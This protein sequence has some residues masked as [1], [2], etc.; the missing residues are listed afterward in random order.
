MKILSIFSHPD[1]ETMLAGGTLALLASAGV[2]M[3]YLCATRGEGGELGDPPIC[4][5]DEIGQF[6]EQELACAVSALGGGTLTFLNFIDP[7]VGE[8]DKLYPYTED[9]DGLVEQITNQILVIQPDAVITH[10]ANGEYGHPGHILT[11]Q[12]VKLALEL[13]RDGRPRKTFQTFEIMLYTFCADFPSHPRPRHANPDNPAHII[14]DVTPVMAQKE[15]AA[16]CHRSQTALFV[17]RRSK[18]AG[19]PL[20]VPEILQSVESLHRVYPQV[21]SLPDDDLIEILKPWV[22]QKFQIEE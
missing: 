14:L 12:A 16:Y 3:H 5:R 18:R 2:E 15:K 11:H 19:F 20:T 6:R 4:I 13:L 9:F 7:L 22:S 10:G 21:N 1:D 17:R 8:G